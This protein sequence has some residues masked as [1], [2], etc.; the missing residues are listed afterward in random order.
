[1]KVL[2]FGIAKLIEKAA[3]SEL[4]TRTAGAPM[5]D[6]GSVVGTVLYMSPE[7][8]QGLAVDP[9]S[10]IFSFGV[11]LYE[12]LTGHPPFSEETKIAT[13]AA[14]LDRD[15]KPLAPSIP[16]ELDRIVSR[17]LKKDPARRFQTMADL[18][19]A[20]EELKD[21]SE[22][23]RLGAF[24]P[25]IR[26]RSP[27]RALLIGALALVIV[28]VAVMWSWPRLGPAAPPSLRQLTFDAGNSSSPSLS[29]DGKLVA[30]QSDRGGTGRHDIWVQQTSGGAPIRLTAE[31]GNHVFPLFS[32]DGSKVYFESTGPPAGIYEVSAL[33]GEA[34]MIA[35]GGF[36]A[37]L[38]HDG[39]HLTFITRPGA[40]LQVMS[41]PG[42]E[43]RAI[44]QEFSMLG[45]RPVWFADSARV[46]MF[47]Q[48]TGQPETREW[49]S[50][51][52]SGGAPRQLNWI[53]W[54]TE[55]QYVGYPSFLGDDW[56]LVTLA[57]RSGENQQIY[58]MSVRNDEPAGEPEP[59]TGGAAWSGRASLAQGTIA[60]QSGTPELGLWSIPADT[61]A[62]RV[63]GNPVRLNTDK[64]VVGSLSST[65]DGK[66]IV[67]ASNKTGTMEVHM[68]ML[69]SGRDRVLTSGSP[70]KSKAHALIGRDASKVLYSMNAST[71]FTQWDVYEFDLSS[72]QTRKI[73]ESCGPGVSLAPDSQSFLV[74]RFDGNRTRVDIVD[75]RT[76]VSSTLLQGVKPPWSATFSPD[77]SRVAFLVA[78]GP[79]S[80]D[81]YVA[82]VHRMAAIPEAEWTRVSAAPG[83]IRQLFWS[84][85]GRLLYYELATAG[86]AFLMAQRLDSNDGPDGAAF[87][88]YEFG[89]VR[90]GVPTGGIGLG[91]TVISAVPGRFI[92]ILSELS[93]NIWL[94][95]L[96]R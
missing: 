31:P 95:N 73:C 79:A 28:A 54:A 32:G 96:P 72:G 20:L 55:Q 6:E 58:R 57:R 45:A 75:V 76:G 90:P 78:N 65:P 27:W 17:C 34:R 5:T 89:R 42:G 1:V 92:G 49:W 2:D 14:I 30:Y 46:A 15:P 23:G 59:L 94:M 62:G 25:E 48:K 26:S 84:P 74:N 39:K 60:F 53:R 81:V 69:D 37:A 47:A 44:A 43:P 56:A 38:S 36:A 9:R 50:F 24:T 68:R 12:M 21:E 71:N 64:S 7:Q 67:F 13:L 3:D 93:F 87:R 40:G 11:L 86:S 66:A 63:L 51:P 41:M 82:A 22:S 70:E 80:S 8:A 18:K 10:D 33:G 19:V 85:G 61:D 77:G 83:D 35:A 88:V 16:R 4:A 52:L 91:G 29:P